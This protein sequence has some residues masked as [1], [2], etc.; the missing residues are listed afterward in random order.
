MSSLT[1]MLEVLDLFGPQSLRLDA[2]TIA[3]RLKLSRATVYRYVR[4]LCDAGLLSRLDGGAY[5]LGPRIIE[6][7]WMMRQ[8]DPM[9]VTGRKPMRELAEKTGLA[10]FASVFYDGHII[11][12]YIEEAGNAY[13]FAFGRGRPLPLFR[14]AQSK[15]LIAYQ[16]SR[17]LKR[18][19]EERI[20]SD[21]DNTLDWQSFSRI[22]RQIR[23][24][25]YCVTHDELNPGLMG[26]AAPIVSDSGDELA[27]SL[28]AVGNSVNF[29]L[30]CREAVIELII[31]T[32]NNIAYR[33]GIRQNLDDRGIVDE[34]LAADPQDFLEPFIPGERSTVG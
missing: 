19:F 17:R 2:E 18:I 13:S 9:L 24:D 23:K 20:A 12:T 10:I 28:A 11:N 31:S 25:G 6:L 21:P 16:K 14:G 34:S 33:M 15:V 29:R 8:Y 26:V 7:D 3:G 30:L 1:K 5:G 32:A 4:D 27:G 22:V